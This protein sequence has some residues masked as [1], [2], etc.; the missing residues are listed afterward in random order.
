MGSIGAYPEISRAEVLARFCYPVTRWRARTFGSLVGLFAESLARANYLPAITPSRDT[1]TR[2]MSA[3][4]LTP[5]Q[6]IPHLCTHLASPAPELRCGA[7]L[8]LGWMGNDE[9]VDPLVAILNLADPDTYR[10]AVLSLYRLQE[11]RIVPV[12]CGMALDTVFQP[13]NMPTAALRSLPTALSSEI[14]GLLQAT[15]TPLNSTIFDWRDILAEELDGPNLLPETV[16]PTFARDALWRLGEAPLLRAVRELSDGEPCYAVFLNDPRL[17]PCY[18]VA[19]SQRQRARQAKAAIRGLV[20]L[21][22]FEALI[23]LEAFASRWSALW[24]DGLTRRE[25]RDAAVVL[26]QRLGAI[27]TEVAP[28]L[29]PRGDGGE[30]VAASVARALETCLED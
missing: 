25:C 19:L 7:A 13:P 26:R 6:V 10:A 21:G 22:S 27:G 8:A 12:L 2:L 29:P 4:E 17:L 18:C 14:L 11:P 5:E 16:W 30:V 3:L 20:G 9:A 28:C 15:G 23:V 1:A 24:Y